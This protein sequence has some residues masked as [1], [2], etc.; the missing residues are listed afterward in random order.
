MLL[1]TPLRFR[2][3]NYEQQEMNNEIQTANNPEFFL[4]EWEKFHQKHTEWFRK[5]M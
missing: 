4:S 3:Y 5:Y 2:S 1:F